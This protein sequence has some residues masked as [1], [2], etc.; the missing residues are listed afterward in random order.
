M[1]GEI[2]EFTI[3]RTNERVS[4]EKKVVVWLSTKPALH[5]I[6]P[7]KFMIRNVNSRISEPKIKCP[8]LSLQVARDRPRVTLINC[9]WEEG[10]HGVKQLGWKLGKS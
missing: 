8:V 10:K 6:E 3:S 1:R 9:R 2:V 4:E 7:N 5:A